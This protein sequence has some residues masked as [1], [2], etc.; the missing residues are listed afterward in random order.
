MAPDGRRRTRAVDGVHEVT[1]D[2]EAKT[3]VISYDKSKTTV[4]AL[5]DVIVAAGYQANKK[6]AD[7]EAYEGLAAC[8]K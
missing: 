4:S 7:P 2:L 5:E 1:V 8:C 6:L 3:T